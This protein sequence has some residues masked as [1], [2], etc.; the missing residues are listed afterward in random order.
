MSLKDKI[1]ATLLQWQEA[2]LCL[3]R[4]WWRP[5]SCIGIAGGSIVN[6]V[7]IPLYKM[8][9]PDMTAAAAY[10]TAMAAAF[11]VRAFE[12]IKGVT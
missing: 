11:G 3:V 2:A 6:L 5:V 10:V 8:E 12:K 1:K 4:K 7:I 9:V